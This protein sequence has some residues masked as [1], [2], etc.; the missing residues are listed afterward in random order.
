MYRQ[1]KSNSSNGSNFGETDKQGKQRVISYA[2]KQLA[3]HE[4]W[5]P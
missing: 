2:S 1:Q 4:K 5:Q 3:K